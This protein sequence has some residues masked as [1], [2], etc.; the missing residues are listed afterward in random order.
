MLAGGASMQKQLHLHPG[1]QRH[2]KESMVLQ[3]RLGAAVLFVM[4]SSCLFAAS[5]GAAKNDPAPGTAWLAKPSVTAGQSVFV[6]GNNEVAVNL[7]RKIIAT[8]LKYGS[9][10]CLNLM[11][12]PK[13][14]QAILKVGEIVAASGA[15]GRWTVYGTATLT[16][17][18]GDFLWAD[19]KQGMMGFIH[20]GA[21][22]AAG[23]LLNS[24]YAAA[25][26]TKDGE[27]AASDHQ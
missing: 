14:A 13:P 3:T 5:H 8:D 16:S 2:S 24:L 21:G 12:N 15:N 9:G 18:N 17:A 7:R 19:S 1:A 6:T 11:Q 23:D 20:S 26:C 27:V 10:A 25:G 22:D 4:V